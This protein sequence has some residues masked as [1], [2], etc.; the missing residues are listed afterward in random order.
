MKMPR[1]CQNPKDWDCLECV[2]NWD[3]E[4]VKWFLENDKFNEKGDHWEITN[5]LAAS[6]GGSAREKK[7]KEND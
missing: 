4:V 3:F 1:N 5:W 6:D 2:K 7:A